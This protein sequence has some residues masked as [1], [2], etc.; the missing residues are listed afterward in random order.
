[1]ARRTCHPDHTL[2]KILKDIFDERSELT[3]C[4]GSLKR[5]AIYLAFV[6]FC[7]FG[8]RPLVRSARHDKLLWGQLLC[9]CLTK[10]SGRP[11][12]RPLSYIRV[13]CILLDNGL[14]SVYDIDTRLCDSLDAAACEVIDALNHALCTNLLD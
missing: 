7:S 11:A 6:D 10:K 3:L 13:S 8:R 2:M 9:H 14:L 1:M 4:E 5:Y 12:G